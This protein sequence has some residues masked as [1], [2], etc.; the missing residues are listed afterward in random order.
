M[1][2]RRVLFIRIEPTGYV[3]ALLRALREIWPDEIEAYFISASASQPWDFDADDAAA[4]L[5]PEDP[6]QARAVIK[7]RI[8][9]AP[10]PALVH[11]AGWGEKACRAA[12]A[13]AHGAKIPVVVDHDTW[14]D[15]ASGL[16]RLAKTVILPRRLAKITHFAS[17][18]QRQ[19]AFLKHY[20]VPAKK[21]TLA[22]MTVDVLKIQRYL[23]ENPN[24]GRAF[25][26][27]YGLPENARVLL[28]LGR[29]VPRKG[30]A[31][32]LECWRELT[33]N[34]DDLHLVIAGEGPLMEQVKGTSHAR[35]HCTGRLSGDEVWDAYAAAHVFVAPS[36]WEPW[37][38][39]INEAMAAG[40]PVVM[41]D[42]FGCIG[43]LALADQTV[44]IARAGDAH[45]LR[46]CLEKVLRDD[47]FRQ[48][49]Q[50]RAT[51]AIAGWTIE[52]QAERIA[53]IWFSQLQNA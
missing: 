31:V 2:G 27:R 9:D 8:L 38:L 16:A 35:I 45:D 20:G 19:A 42:A 33:A 44:C 29:L 28:F 39:T 21:I 1:S 51:E 25:R 32:L 15:A 30:L 17:G 43:D 22:N 48:R 11:T 3:L 14:T 24:A 37:G 34:Y 23:A 13:F 36:L 41:S 10:R 46:A 53:K 5:L 49:L 40:V 47:D 26:R 18:G 50:R 4:S 12:I 6:V 7:G 52:A